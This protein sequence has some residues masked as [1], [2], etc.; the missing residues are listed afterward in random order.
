MSAKDNPTDII[1]VR[2]E[3][4]KK[5]RVFTPSFRTC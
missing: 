1:A 2:V 3:K 5:I 4:V